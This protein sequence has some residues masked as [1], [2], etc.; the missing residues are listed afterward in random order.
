[1]GGTSQK[2][3]TVEN[4]RYTDEPAQQKLFESLP[5]VKTV[6]S[7]QSRSLV[8][9]KLQ[10]CSVV[11]SSEPEELALYASQKQEKRATLIE[12]VEVCNA[13]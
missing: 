5:A 11:F 10:L 2:Q 8:H 1:M 9:K 4:V 3:I 12:L 7:Y 13:K 6:P